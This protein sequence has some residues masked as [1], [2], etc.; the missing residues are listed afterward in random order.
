MNGIYFPEGIIISDN[1]N[2]AAFSG[3][4]SLRDAALRGTVLEATALKCDRDHAL[5]VDLGVMPGIIPKNEGAIGIEDGSVRDIALISRVGRPV[6]FIVTEIKKNA[7]GKLYAV[8]SRR[9]AQEKCRSEYIDALLPGDVITA[10]VTRTEPFGVFCDIGCGIP[11]LIPIDAVSVSRIPHPSARFFNGQIIKAIVKSR[12]GNGRIT[13]SHK[14]LLG[15]WEENAAKISVGETVPGIV[16]SVESYGVFVELAPNLA[17]LAEY[18][19]DINE[20]Q[21]AAVF[22]KSIIPEKMKIKLVI[23]DK[24]EPRP[25][26]Y[27]RDYFFRESHMTYFRYSPPECDKT[28]ET[29]FGI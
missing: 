27:V 24:G 17:G 26:E 19:P 5:H 25:P 22:I 6:C 11:A 28:V 16:R 8:L 21:S 7:D 18:D 15:T 12:D 23:V 4:S 9:K 13:L 29:V 14:E 1:E 20:G 10:R 2:R 3:I